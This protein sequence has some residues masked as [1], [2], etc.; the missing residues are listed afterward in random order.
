MT[1]RR[2]QQEG[3]CN[4]QIEVD[5]MSGQWMT[6]QEGAVDDGRQAGVGQCNKREEGECETSRWRLMQGDWVANDTIRG[7]GWRTLHKAM[8]WWTKQR[9]ARVD[10]VGQ[11]DKAGVD[12]TW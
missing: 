10:N 4:N 8:G 11:L 9:E 7:G 5:E 12:N 2:G 1:R 3:E 6:R